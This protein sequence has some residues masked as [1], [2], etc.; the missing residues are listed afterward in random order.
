VTF[1]ENYFKNRQY[2]NKEQ[3]VKRHVLE[4]LLWASKDSHIDLLKGADKRALDIGCATGYTSSVLSDLGYETYGV[5]ISRWGTKQAKRQTD[6]QFVVCDAQGFLS[7][8]PNA[9][10]LVT[11]FDVL[12]HLPFPEKALLD[13]FTASIGTLVC[14]TPNKK[15]E[16]AIR[17][18]IGDYDQTHVSVKPP[19]D[20]KKSVAPLGGKSKIEAYCDIPIRLRGKLFFKSV[21][22]PTY[23]LTVR[24]V[25]W[26]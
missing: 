10:D 7:F 24:I 9:F 19:A 18:F 25:V 21:R 14:T 1:E 3:L 6:G 26:K 13:M 16:K 4:L 12:E 23:G 11:C 17:K 8:L 22:V 20:W 15:V 5:D 2:A